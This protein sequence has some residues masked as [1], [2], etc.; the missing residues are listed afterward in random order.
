MRTLCDGCDVR[1]P[2]EHR[3]HGESCSCLECAEERRL[4]GGAA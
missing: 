2:F 3:C 1:E 4:F